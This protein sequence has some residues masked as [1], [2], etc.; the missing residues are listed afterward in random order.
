MEIKKVMPVIKIGGGVVPIVPKIIS[1]IKPAVIVPQVAKPMAPA[2]VV[3]KV[4]PPVQHAPG[5]LFS[6]APSKPSVADRP[7][8]ER[9]ADMKAAAKGV[10]DKKRAKVTA[11]NEED[12]SDENDEDENEDATPGD[13]KK[14]SKKTK[15][16]EKKKFEGTRSVRVYGQEIFEEENPDIDLEVIRKRIVSEFHYPEFSKERTVMSFDDTTGIIVPCIKFEKKG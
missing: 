5:G 13:D 10:M 3:E 9:I 8:E 2:P 15:T 14:V 1:A 12:S 7:K 4:A 11:S 6:T 16:P